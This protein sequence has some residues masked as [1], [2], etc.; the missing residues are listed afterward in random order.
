M[1][2]RMISPVWFAFNGI[3]SIFNLI[4][5]LPQYASTSK[6]IYDTLFVSTFFWYYI[7]PLSF[8]F[9]VTY[10]R[11]FKLSYVVVLLFY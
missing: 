6:M 9:Y 2:T 10:V 4:S 3:G 1:I 7:I 5:R 11:V 8:N